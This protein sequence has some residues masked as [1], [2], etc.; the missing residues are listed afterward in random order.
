[1]PSPGIQK[2]RLTPLQYAA[3]QERSLINRQALHKVV[4]LMNPQAPQ[5]PLAWFDQ[6]A[7]TYVETVARAQ[8]EVAAL[9][10]EATQQLMAEQ[11][12]PT[13]R[14]I[15]DPSAFIGET[16]DGRPTLGLAY[17]AARRAA[18]PIEAEQ[19]P[20]QR[21]R[22][23][24]QAA[25]M[26]VSLTQMAIADAGR[27]A[28]SVQTVAY[29]G[30]G[31][32]RVV[33]APCCSRCAI[34]AGRLYKATASF[35]RHPNCDCDSIPVHQY[36]D[37][38]DEL[39][40]KGLFFDVRDYFDS[41]DTKTQNKIFTVSGAEAIRDGADPA[42]VVNARRGMRAAAGEPAPVYTNSGTVKRGWAAQYLREA[43]NRH[44][45]MTPEEL[46]PG[47]RGRRT[48]LMPEEIYRRAGGDQDV[49]LM[50]LH[51]H[52]YLRDATPTLRDTE[53]WGSRNDEVR[54]ATRR[55]EHRLLGLG[56]QDGLGPYRKIRVSRDGQRTNRGFQVRPFDPSMDFKGP[57]P[58]P[59]PPQTT[60]FDDGED[61]MRRIKVEDGAVILQDEWPA[62]EAL[63]RNG[64]E[65]IWLNALRTPEYDEAA[66]KEVSKNPDMLL[67]LE[68]AELKSPVGTPGKTQQGWTV[69]T[70]LDRALKQAPNAVIDLLYLDCSAETAM[71]AISDWIAKH[72]DRTPAS[73]RVISVERKIHVWKEE[74]QWTPAV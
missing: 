29:P 22:A 12:A 37:R 49:A 20:W 55:A 40:Q 44:L 57:N 74:S 18:E 10:V 14:H 45:Y 1:M 31:W 70:N 6:V 71:R 4:G 68:V 53:L 35:D 58:P 42:L 15:A 11:G 26:L 61:W 2:D 38:Y 36:A 51:Q 66:Q 52:G 7:D 23:W 27:M 24:Q 34:L 41:L 46:V 59:L 28:K 65:V 17:L 32:I 54:Q 39:R 63:A 60:G 43:Y 48:R 73:V 50:M 62:V 30:A 8:L 3:M 19:E 69:R 16:G 21:A 9:G 56:S 33:R 67:N 47:P 25:H 13:P 72:P 64:D 5:D